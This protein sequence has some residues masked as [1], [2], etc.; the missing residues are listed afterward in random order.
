VDRRADAVLADSDF[1]APGLV[2][3]WS[4]LGKRIG[5]DVALIGWGYESVGR[6][7][8]PALTTVDFN[9]PEIVSKALEVLSDLIEKPE[10]QRPQSILIKPKLIVRESA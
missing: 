8:H 2:R 9:F 4:E 3:A 6:G 7:V 1:S 10:E 5:D